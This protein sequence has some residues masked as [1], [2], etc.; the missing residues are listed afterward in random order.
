MTPPMASLPYKTE[1]PL[2]T[3]STR[4]ILS[5]AIASRL[6][7]PR[8]DTG[9]PFTKIKVPL[10][11]PRIFTSL[12]IVPIDAPAGPNCLYATPGTLD[13]ATPKLLAPVSFNSFP[14]KIVVLAG[15]STSLFSYLVAVTTIGSK[16]NV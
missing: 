3:I 16:V 9:L 8:Q 6:Y 5:T 10:L 4:S 14:V 2:L 12:I 13:S 1:P 15:T 7:F 11:T